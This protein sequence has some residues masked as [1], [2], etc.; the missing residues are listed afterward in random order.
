MGDKEN[1][2]FDFTHLITPAK[3]VIVMPA[4]YRFDFTG[5]PVQSGWGWL[6][7]SDL[8][9]AVNYNRWLK[10]KNALTANGISREYSEVFLRNNSLATVSHYGHIG[11]GGSPEE[12]FDY[13]VQHAEYIPA[14]IGTDLLRLVKAG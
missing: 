8:L 13:C 12:W 14:R 4:V 5:F 9:T 2:M 6:L 1:R 7:A 3:G 11:G 10:G